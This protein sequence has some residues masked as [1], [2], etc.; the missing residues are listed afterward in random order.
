MCAGDDHADPPR[1]TAPRAHRHFS[2]HVPTPRI[3]PRIRDPG[4]PRARSDGTTEPLEPDLPF[5]SEPSD[6]ADETFIAMME[7]L[8]YRPV[9]LP[10]SDQIG[11]RRR[12]AAPPAEPDDF[13]PETEQPDDA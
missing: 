10:G 8:G 11:W 6:L 5:T 1:D 7:H 2:G 13:Y 3:P 9:D 4:A 12:D